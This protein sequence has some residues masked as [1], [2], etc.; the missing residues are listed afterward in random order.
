MHVTTLKQAEGGALV[1]H[2]DVSGWVPAGQQ[3]AT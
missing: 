1:T 3:G 2:Y